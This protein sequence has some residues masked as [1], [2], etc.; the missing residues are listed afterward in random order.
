MISLGFLRPIEI[1]ALV[2]SATTAVAVAALCLPPGVAIAWLLARRSFRGKALL[3]TLVHLPLVLPPVVVGYGLLALFGREGPL[4]RLSASFG[5]DI[6][7]TP[8]AIVIAGATMVIPLLIRSARLAFESVDPGLEEAARSLGQGPFSTWWRISLPLARP[9]ILAGV[10][11]C[12]ARA[13][14]EFGATIT[15][16]GNIAGE[17]RTLPLLIHTELQTPGGE[18]RLGPLIAISVAISFVALLLSELG[19]RRVRRARTEGGAR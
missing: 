12:F 1:E 19:A 11:L 16:A 10:V 18:L 7:F 5:Y 15:F 13:L 17:T 2:L 14:G 4:G 9:G 8:A 6:A 3:D